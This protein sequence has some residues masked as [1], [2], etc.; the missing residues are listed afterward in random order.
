MSCASD[1]IRVQTPASFLDY[2]FNWATWPLAV[3]ET[4]V[5]SQWDVDLITV[6]PLVLSG[7]GIVDMA[8]S[9][10][11]ESAGVRTVVWITGGIPDRDYLVT[12]SITTSEARQFSQSFVLQVR[13]AVMA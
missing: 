6:P 13:A 9:S 2:G 3:G 5:S 10:S 7:D 12:N 8:G 4:L 1:P 11:E